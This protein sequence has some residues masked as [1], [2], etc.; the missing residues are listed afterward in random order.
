MYDE[1]YVA[2]QPMNYT[3]NQE[4]IQPS[5]SYNQTPIKTSQWSSTL[6]SSSNQT[7]NSTY[8]PPQPFNPYN[9]YPF[10]L[11]P[12]QYMPRSIFIL[13]FNFSLNL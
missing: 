11:Y 1:N 2:S 3:N 9:P 4:S 5:Q 13:H 12:P 7:P 10:F 8:P 6:A